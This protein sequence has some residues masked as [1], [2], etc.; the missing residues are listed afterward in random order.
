MI[1]NNTTDLVQIWKQTCHMHGTIVNNI[2]WS[3][4]YDQTLMLLCCLFITKAR[5]YFLLFYST[6]KGNNVGK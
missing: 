5:L 2:L 4:N 1:L 6:V 3:S